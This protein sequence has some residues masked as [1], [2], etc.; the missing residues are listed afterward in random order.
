M[1]VCT[2]LGALPVLVSRPV[3]DI[4]D[5]YALGFTT[6]SELTS[7]FKANAG[8]VYVLSAARYYTK[9]E[10]KW[11]MVELKVRVVFEPLTPLPCR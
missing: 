6:D 11:Y 1:C 7:K 9:H 4:R 10:P 2:R 3:Q 5:E 8:S